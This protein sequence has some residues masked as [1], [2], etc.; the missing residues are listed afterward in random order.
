MLL[1]LAAVIDPPQDQTG[2]EPEPLCTLPSVPGA[3]G[4]RACLPLSDSDE[5]DDQRQTSVSVQR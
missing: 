5:E 2:A 4:L 1:Q 3:S